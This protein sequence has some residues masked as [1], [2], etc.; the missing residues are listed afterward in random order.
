M[1]VT[2]YIP[3]LGRGV[4]RVIIGGCKVSGIFAA[5]LAQCRE[6]D[7]GRARR[8]VGAGSIGT[9]AAVERRLAQVA[10]ISGRR[11]LVER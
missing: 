9:L 8:K 2:G 11:R 1:Q 7:A 5:L 4:A 6:A 10:L 3:R